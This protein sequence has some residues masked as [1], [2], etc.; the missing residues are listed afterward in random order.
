M[1]SAPL[2]VTTEFNWYL[3]SKIVSVKS[4]RLYSDI[5]MFCQFGVKSRNLRKMNFYQ[6]NKSEKKK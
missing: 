2:L 5:N 4:R 6:K 3:Q 1:L